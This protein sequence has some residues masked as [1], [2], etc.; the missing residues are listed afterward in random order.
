MRIFL[1]RACFGLL[2]LWPAI[3]LSAKNNKKKDVEA[4]APKDF[5]KL[6]FKDILDRYVFIADF[7]QKPA[8]RSISK[9]VFWKYPFK[10]SPVTF[11]LDF[12]SVDLKAMIFQ[13]K[14]SGSRIEA[15]NIGRVAFMDGK[16]QKAHQ[17]WLAGREDIKDDPKTNKVFE[18]YLGVNAL[19]AYREKILAVKGDF[20]DPEVQAYA[21]RVA[22]FF[23][24]TFIQKRDVLDPRIDQYAPWGLYN[25]AVIYYR[26]DRMPS[27]YGAAQEGL[28]ALLKLGQ[29]AHRAEFRQLLA[30]A[31]IRNQDLISAI[32]ELDTAIRQDPSPIQATRMF[33]R[34]ADIYY[35]LNNYEL[36]EDFYAMASAIDRERL[37]Y[38][39]GQAFLRAESIFWLGRFKDV[40]KILRGAVEFASK[41]NARESEGYARN[42]P[43]AWLRIADTILARASLENPES[44]KAQLDKARLAYFKVETEFPKTEAAQIASIRGACMELPSYQGNN[45]KHAR[46]YLEEIKAKADI[47]EVL[48]ELVWACNAA[49]Y[50]D[51]D[52][53]DVMVAKIK[54]FADKYPRSR[55]LEPMLPP[56]RDVQASKIDEYFAKKQWE[57]AIDFFEEKKSALFQK[58]PDHTAASLWT[59]YVST[60]QSAKAMPFS[61]LRPKS[62]STDLEALRQAAFLFEAT[63]EKGGSTLTKDRSLLN[64]QLIKRDWK[65]KPGQEEM[66]YLARVMTTKD[67]AQAYPWILNIQDAW[68][69]TDEDSI[70]TTL[71]PLLSRINSDKKANVLG[72]AAVYKR[73]LNLSDE[74]VQGILSKD[75]SCFQS[76]LDL[77]AKIL[78]SADLKKKYDKRAEWKLEG[79]WLERV[80]A[81]SE[82]LNAKKT[83]QD[84]IPIWQRI[85]E[86]APHDS[87]EWRMAKTRLDPNKTEFESLWK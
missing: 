53:N 16:Y 29:T 7:N 83:R 20:N 72:R 56:V 6:S 74:K 45:V 37:V 1:T 71:F 41:A 27:V 8:E 2:L 14:G 85:S 3:E 31:H 69:K 39:P 28:A 81:W 79:P 47:P 66:D 61:K 51:R 82:D 52:K 35:D 62:T 4:E 58:I 25:L 78:T 5:A 17:V 55:F 75:K 60:N 22:Y 59:A 19:A 26:F 80:W 68:T 33:N 18:F 77:E 36:A 54:D 34:A 49:S 24:S 21:K 63:S 87:F 65:P 73:V 40:E 13:V 15:M 38:N 57:N 10:L 48:M 30:E 86:K 67:V 11:D 46:A 23:A 42:I 84:A 76:W 9:E 43:W 12:E 64:T 50:S 32:Q 44:K 70:C